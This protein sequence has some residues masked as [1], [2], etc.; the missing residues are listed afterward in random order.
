MKSLQD[1]LYNW[2]TI[3]V[4]CDARPDDTAARE[5]EMFFMQLLKDDHRVNIDSVSRAEPFYFVEY[6]MDEET[7]KQRFPI[8]LIDIMLDQIQLEPEKYKNI[9]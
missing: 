1:A 5:T 2:L 4:V 3:K 8:E 7:K 6:T 9:E